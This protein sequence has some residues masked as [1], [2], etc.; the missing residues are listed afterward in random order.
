MTVSAM[1]VSAAE[2]RPL[3]S[4]LPIRVGLHLIFFRQ[5]FVS[6][7]TINTRLL[8]LAGSAHFLTRVRS[9]LFPDHLYHYTM[10][11]PPDNQGAWDV[12]SKDAKRLLAED[13]YDDCLACRVTG[14]YIRLSPVVETYSPTL[15]QLPRMQVPRHS[16]ASAFTAI[17]P[18]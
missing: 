16:S 9:L 1:S 18:A 2:R 5:S 11:P 8:N 10:A 14:K 12:Q 3:L 6:D 7:G 13:Q 17:T 4:Y 15:T